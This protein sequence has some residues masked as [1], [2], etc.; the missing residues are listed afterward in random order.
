MHSRKDSPLKNPYPAANAITK[1]RKDG[2]I[3]IIS[4]L[5]DFD[6]AL[7]LYILLIF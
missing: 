1:Y 3:L 5:F 6:L 4:P 7:T 2:R